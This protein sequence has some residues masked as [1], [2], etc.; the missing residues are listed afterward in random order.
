MVE[1][2]PPRPQ[3]SL[4]H[5]T[6]LHLCGAAAVIGSG[7]D[8]CSTT[9]QA[10]F[11]PSCGARVPESY[12]WPSGGK[13]ASTGR[14]RVYPGR[15]TAGQRHARGQRT[16][17]RDGDGNGHQSIIQRVYGSRGCSCAGAPPAPIHIDLRSRHEGPWSV[18]TTP[19]RLR[20]TLDRQVSVLLHRRG[21]GQS[22]E[23]AAAGGPQAAGVTAPEPGAGRAQREPWP[24]GPR[25][26]Q[27]QAAA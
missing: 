2:A 15:F 22:A 9:A 1:P 10:D 19:H 18:G 6:C 12:F 13:F 23:G 7:N 17:T 16:P 26:W 4:R 20:E 25:L 27:S 14:S 24:A 5:R 8:G 21:S 11:Q 3:H